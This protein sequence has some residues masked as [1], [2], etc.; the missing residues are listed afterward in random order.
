[1]R[2]NPELLT[3]E[4]L[5]EEMLA[6]EIE[7]ESKGC[8]YLI[9]M[10]EDRARSFFEQVRWPRGAICVRC[11]SKDVVY[12]KPRC[13]SGGLHECMRCGT[14]F[15]VTAETPVGRVDVPLKTWLMAIYFL[16]CTA[17]RLNVLELS[18]ILGVRYHHV[19]RITQEVGM[20]TGWTMAR[21]HVMFYSLEAAAF[22][23]V[24]S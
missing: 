18:R 10:D 19:R 8:L 23:V 21:S 7:G 22:K 12:A 14:R 13:R 1:M 15:D 6:P 9:R 5:S 20:A 16:C 2:K 11:R 24:R 3:L 17:R 4:T